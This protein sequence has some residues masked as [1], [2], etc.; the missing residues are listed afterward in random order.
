VGISR[1]DLIR[2]VEA[3]FPIRYYSEKGDGY[4]RGIPLSVVEK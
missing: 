3:E 1:I 4:G 2:K